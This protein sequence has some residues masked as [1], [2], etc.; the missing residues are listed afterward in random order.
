MIV[1]GVLYGADIDVGLWVQSN[2]GGV[3]IPGPFVALGGVDST[4]ELT[5][6]VIWFNE[7]DKDIEAAIY[8]TSSKQATRTVM[9]RVFAHAFDVV[10]ANRITAEIDA[11]NARAIRFVI[12]LGFQ[13]EGRKRRAC[14][15]GG[16]R[17]VFGLLRDD[18]KFV[19]KPLEHA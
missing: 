8:A 12:K 16:D 6:G 5:F 4:G 7:R 13:L 18:C 3:T 1:D 2:L 11:V 14:L 15:D 17:L 10:K 9:R 19:A